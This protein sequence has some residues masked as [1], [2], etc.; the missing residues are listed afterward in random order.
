MGKTIIGLAGR[1][2]CGKTSAALKLEKSGFVRLSFASPMREMLKALLLDCGYLHTDIELM[3][4][5]SERKEKPI[6]FIGRSTR[7]LLQT[8]GTE[9]GRN[10]VNSELWVLAAKLKI[11]A[12]DSD[13]IVFDD[14]RFENE[15]DMIRDLGGLIIHI[16]RGDLIS[17]RHASETGILDHHSDAFIDNDH[18]LQDFLLDVSIIVAG[19]IGR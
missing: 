10:C 13:Y 15:A 7:Y 14:V 8:L 9:W 18:S 19:H 6:A 2:Q 11:E 4:S 3:F 16:D 12:S 17:D 5:V 1:K